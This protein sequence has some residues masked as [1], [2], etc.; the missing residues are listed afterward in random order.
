[1]ENMIIQKKNAQNFYNNEVGFKTSAS[2]YNI[3]DSVEKKS[4]PLI[5]SINYLIDD[6]IVIGM[7]KNRKISINTRTIPEPNPNNSEGRVFSGLIHVVDT[8]EYGEWCQ[9]AGSY[10]SVT[11]LLRC[12]TNDEF[13]HN[14]IWLKELGKNNENTKKDFAMLYKVE[15]SKQNTCRYSAFVCTNVLCNH[16][17][18]QEMKKF[19]H[20][21]KYTHDI[22]V[23]Y[24]TEYLTPSILHTSGNLYE[25]EG[26]KINDPSKKSIIH[27]LEDS[28]KDK[29]LKRDEGW[30]IYLYCHKSHVSQFH[31]V[32]F[33]DL[34]R[35]TIKMKV[36]QEYVLGIYNEQNIDG[37]LVREG[38]THP[39]TQQISN[40]SSDHVFLRN[41]RTTLDYYDT[42]PVSSHYSQEYGGG[43][44]CDVK[45]TRV[46]LQNGYFQEKR[47]RRSTTVR[48]FCGNSKDITRV[49]EDSSCHYIIDITVPELCSHKY[50]R[51]PELST[52]IIKCV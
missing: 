15:E 35:G 8:F 28:F 2:A 19:T 14:M 16:A 36:D 12:C 7:Y 52:Q 43:D 26:L 50:F 47:L 21:Q 48:F 9:E 27:I 42:D 31:Q 18:L 11:V 33:R 51:V 30:W 22:P 34:N 10:R 29:C 25:K 40:L 37:N 24:D 13:T 4:P 6:S 1:M 39:V 17:F 5:K 45:N 46:F 20:K 44:F 3:Q 49:N 41:S 32:P 38:I 23:T